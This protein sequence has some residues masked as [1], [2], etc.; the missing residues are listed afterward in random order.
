[1]KKL[2]KT[3]LAIGVALAISA[4]N[5]MAVGSFQTLTSEAVGVEAATTGVKTANISGDSIVL[6]AGAIYRTGAGA[7][8]IL[9]LD[10][11]ATFSDNAYTLEVSSGGAGTGDLTVWTQTTSDSAS[12]LQFSPTTSTAVGANF[13]LSGSSVAG[14][15]VNMVVPSL[16]SGD[17]IKI[18]GQY[19]DS[20]STTI[21]TYNPLELFEYANQFSASI[22]TT[23]DGIVDVN[24]SRLS[25]TGAASVDTVALDFASAAVVNG[26]TLTDD[27]SVDIVLSGDMSGIASIG[28]TTNG[29]S[30]GNATIDTDANTASISLSASDAFFG[31]GS[32]VMSVNVTGS[33]ALATRTFTV[34]ADLD[35]DAEVDKNL[36]AE[37][38][39]AGQWTING[40]Q[41]KVSHMSLNTT[42][43]VSWLK[44]VNEGTSAAAITA[45][46]IYTLA[47][48]TEGS[49]SGAGL[50]T[51]DAGGIATI[52]EATIL[53]AMGNPTQLADVSMTVTVAGQVDL[54]HLVAEK[55][56]SD[57]RLPIPVYYNTTG[58]NA[59]SWV[60]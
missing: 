34:Q 45:D 41:A 23:A 15:A 48:G 31:T 28:V 37:A 21:E 9:T 30:R 11:G 17:E 59:R 57:G 32:A 47:D 53:T 12:E 7:R 5:A 40:L 35:F 49:V 2:N 42:G 6:D 52:G 29:T 43:F 25:F 50:G 24:D 39:S 55:K 60:Q 10:N 46:I 27:D 14:E 38:T 16:N 33:A 13:I 26:V 1:M 56:A 4:S 44:V 58:A 20:P 8:L 22:D 18:T 19:K 3:G 36:V 51:V 54:V